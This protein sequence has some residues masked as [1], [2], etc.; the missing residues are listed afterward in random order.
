MISAVVALCS[1]LAYF[2]LLNAPIGSA[3]PAADHLAAV[4]E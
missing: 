1:A 3:E 4:T 2:L